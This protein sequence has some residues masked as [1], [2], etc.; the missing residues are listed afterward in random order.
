MI[1]KAIFSS[2]ID[3]LVQKSDV[4]TTFGQSGYN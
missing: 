4:L 2:G 1:R 3:Y